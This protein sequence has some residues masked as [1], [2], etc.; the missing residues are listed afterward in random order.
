MNSSLSDIGYAEGSHG[1]T[2]KTKG[3]PNSR[4]R[5]PYCSKSKFDLRAHIQIKHPNQARIAEERMLASAAAVTALRTKAEKKAVPN[6]KQEKRIHK[7]MYFPNKQSVQE[8]IDLTKRGFI[9]IRGKKNWPFLP[10]FDKAEEL[11][12]VGIVPAERATADDCENGWVR[13]GRTD[14]TAAKALLRTVEGV[15]GWN[16]KN[17]VAMAYKVTA[18]LPTMMTNGQTSSTSERERNSIGTAFSYNCIYTI[19]D[20]KIMAVEVLRGGPVTFHENKPW[21]M[22]YKLWQ[23]AQKAQIPMPVLF[24]D[25]ARYTN[26]LFYWGVL[27]AIE[28][29]DDGTTVTVDRLRRFSKSRKTQELVLRSTGQHIAPNYIYP[30]AICRTPSFISK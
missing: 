4:K 14:M 10:V 7:L 2:A 6:P 26:K 9:V 1:V 3:H 19:R 17:A 12:V 23:E 15:W 16:S 13:E 5:C 20:R 30:Y 29:T 28:L 22:G 8:L 25:A 11:T 18:K 27:T 21:V 24:A